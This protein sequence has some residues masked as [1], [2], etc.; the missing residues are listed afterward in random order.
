MKKIII[1]AI[2]LLGSAP[3]FAQN[4]NKI[5][6]CGLTP[7]QAIANE[8]MISARNENLRQIESEKIQNELL[9]NN[10]TAINQNNENV[11]GFGQNKKMPETKPG[12]AIN[13]EKPKMDAV[14]NPISSSKAKTDTY[15]RDD[16]SSAAPQKK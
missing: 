7:A 12:E 9:K 8:K 16:Q 15:P 10:Q 11:D 13:T 6:E 4:N 1:I 14:R 3:L 5:N 2:T